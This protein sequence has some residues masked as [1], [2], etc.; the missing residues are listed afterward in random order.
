MLLNICGWFAVG[1]T[2]AGMLGYIGSDKYDGETRVLGVLL[3][4]PVLYF[5]FSTLL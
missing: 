1:I 5:L 4:I 3:R 2:L